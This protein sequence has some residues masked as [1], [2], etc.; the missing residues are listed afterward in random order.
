[1][2]PWQVPLADVKVSDDDVAG[3]ADALRSGWLSMGPRT[4]R[5]EE[6]FAAYTGARHAIA[7][8]NGTAALHLA[9]L[10]AGVRPGDEVVL[11]SMTFVATANAVRYTGA[12][13]VFAEVAG[14]LEPWLSAAAAERAITPRTRVILTVD[15]AGQAGELA[16]LSEL[17]R[18]HGIALLEDAAHAAGGRLHGRHLGTFGLAGAFSLFSTK[19]LSVGEGGVLVTDDDE[20]AA[21]V[22]LLRSHGMTS[23]SRD[24]YD[25]RATDYDVVALGFNYRLDEPRAELASRRLVRLDAENACRAVLVGRYRDALGDLPGLAVALPAHRDEQPAHHLFTVVLDDRL[26]RAAFRASL[27]GRGI[28]TSVHYPP[29]HRLALYADGARSLPTTERYGAQAVTLPLFA[30]M[31]SAQVDL[32]CDAVADAAGSRVG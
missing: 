31:S 18:S 32:V 20:V 28:E 24:R 19:N 3:V 29:V 15:Y 17:A 14:P 22:R 7:V 5:F 30:H 1:M 6:A 26:D 13:P 16:G 11:P 12:T 23:L 10:A 27:A 9:C 25:R 2:T 8:A 4:E 21:R